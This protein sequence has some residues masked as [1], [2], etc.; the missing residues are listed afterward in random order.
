MNE[1]AAA[2]AV[3]GIDVESL[4]LAVARHWGL[5]D[6]VLH[7]IRRLPLETPVRHADD[8]T[9][10][11]RQVASAGNEIVDVLATAGAASGP[12]LQ[13]VALRY[14]RALG[15]SAKELQDA[16]AASLRPAGAEPPP[17]RPAATGGRA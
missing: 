12:A 3:L 5:D 11:L 1:Q 4:G 8:D 16:V 17:A 13:R 7:M 10:L 9:E 15:L 14:A 6:T 2:F